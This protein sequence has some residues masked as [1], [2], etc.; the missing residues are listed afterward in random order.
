MPKLGL[1]EPDLA[2]SNS[3]GTEAEK[4]LI[5]QCMTS[6]QINPFTKSTFNACFTHIFVVQ[7]RLTSEIL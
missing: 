7:T 1:I 3:P 4:W 5:L 2:L 6:A